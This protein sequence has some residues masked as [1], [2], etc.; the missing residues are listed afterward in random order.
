LS[1]PRRTCTD[2]RTTLAWQ[3]TALSLLGG[4]VLVS[5]L[6]YPRIGML[7]LAGVVVLLPLGV[8]TLL[9]GRGG[10][11]KGPGAAA[12]AGIGALLAV[13]VA[14]TAV[15]ELVALAVGP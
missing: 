9:L 3:R 6:A 13:A 10:Q 4:S 14:V 1:T 8:A 11:R 7:A 2:D 12:R 15:T 5:R